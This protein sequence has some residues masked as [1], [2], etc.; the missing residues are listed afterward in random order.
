MKHLNLYD[1]YKHFELSTYNNLY[2][3]VSGNIIDKVDTGFRFKIIDDILTQR[4]EIEYEIVND[5]R[6][7]K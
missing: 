7:V 3:Q 4:I 5:N 1:V 2:Y 6:K